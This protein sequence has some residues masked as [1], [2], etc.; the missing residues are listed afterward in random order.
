MHIFI[1]LKNRTE[2]LTITI[3]LPHSYFDA[4]PTMKHVDNG[5]KFN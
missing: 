3:A 4:G 2:N 1:E 5:Y